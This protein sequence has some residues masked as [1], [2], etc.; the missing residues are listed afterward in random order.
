VLAK[1]F[2]QASTLMLQAKSRLCRS[3]GVRGRDLQLAGY[4]LCKGWLSCKWSRLWLHAAMLCYPQC[5]LASPHVTSGLKVPDASGCAPSC[6]CRLVRRTLQPSVAPGT[7]Q[8]IAAAVVVCQAAAVSSAVRPREHDVGLGVI[9]NP[10]DLQGSQ[11]CR[12]NCCTL[13]CQ[14]AAEQAWHLL[15]FC[16]HVPVMLLS[17]SNVTCCHMTL[18]KATDHDDAQMTPRSMPMTVL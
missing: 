14:D 1:T 17:C 2:A 5:Y 8:E 7:W 11:M 15:S 10:G 4:A 18:D 9:N 16:C 6:C 3:N 12:T 13:T